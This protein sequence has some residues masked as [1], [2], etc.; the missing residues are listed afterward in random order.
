M[1]NEIDIDLGLMQGKVYFMIASWYNLDMEVSQKQELLKELSFQIPKV[2]LEE[3]FSSIASG[4][5]EIKKKVNKKPGLLD[6]VFG[7]KK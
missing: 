3:A 5:A 1:E 2:I 4:K 6:K 7:R